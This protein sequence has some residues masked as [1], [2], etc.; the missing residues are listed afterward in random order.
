MN[1]DDAKSRIQKYL[2]SDKSWPLI[3][4]VQTKKNLAEIKEFFRV[5]DNK[6]PDIENFCNADGMLK[7]DELYSAIRN[8]SNNLFITCLTGFL[9]LMGESKIKSTLK[10][11]IS[12][13][14]NSRVVI[15][16]YQ[17]KNYLKFS[18]ER[19][20]ESGRFIIVDDIPDE[21]AEIVLVNPSLYESLP[22]AYL[23]IQKVGY[24]IENSYQKRIYVATDVKKES[25]IESVFHISQMTSGYNLL[26]DRDSR[27]S[28]VPE[29]FGEDSQWNY[30]L[31]EMGNKGDWKYVIEK[32]FGSEDNLSQVITTYAHLNKKHLWLYY[33][34]LSICGVKNNAYL[35]MSVDCSSGPA[36]FIKSIYRTILTIDKDNK[37]FASLYE[38]RKII[39]SYLT[40]TLGEMA[41]YCKVISVKG[42]DAIYYLTDLTQLEKER[43]VEWLNIY[44]L[45]YK[46]NELVRILKRVYP[47]LSDYLSDFRFKNELLDDYFEQ[48]KYQ[49]VV[50]HILPSF[51]TLV[52]EQSIKMDFVSALKPRSSI[53]DKVSVDNTQ[54]YFF[55]ALG[56]EYLGFIQA[57]C[58]EYGLSANIKC[59]R[60]EL[61]SLTSFNKEFVDVLKSKG[62]SVT[63]IKE[64]DEIKH[65][66]ENNFDYEKEKN[67]IYLIRELEI[68]NELIDKIKIGIYGGQYKKALI[69]SDHGASRLAVLHETENI[70][71]MESKGEHSGRCCRT[72]EI[73]TKPDF[74]IEQSGFWVLANY[75]R[76]KGGRK[77]N[78]EVHGG[79]TIEEVTIPIIEITQKH[80]DIEAFIIEEY[81]VVSLGAL[82]HAI[83]K[84]YV[85]TKSDNI[86]I[87]IDNKYYDANPTSDIYVYEIEL[88]DYTK[89]GNYK[90]DILNGGEILATDVQFEIKKKG[91]SEV[92]LFD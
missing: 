57:K 35:Q 9:K 43:I 91:M 32:H 48:Y 68:I 60:C 6:F 23:G 17:C 83:I 8:G 88:Q 39:L 44:G 59:A 45:N 36:E 80:Y 87:R 7:L 55:D 61:P 22:G 25:F 4:D 86:S 28:I 53:I 19:I 21:I 27:T 49:K 89:K 18:D 13:D 54:A 71:S 76:F 77:A 3:V 15:I 73:N 1:L 79:A 11:L 56:V 5:G 29:S 72:S 84:I 63:D 66:G 47:D 14:V 78:V 37:D 50:N 10:T 65:H 31:Q 16:T 33:I 26:C 90:F 46:K 75:D 69:V 92:N 52:E 42:E 58:N 38:Q 40:N 70:W 74:A 41:E 24:A 67:P 85:G 20:A 12:T 64:L 62:C 34:A 81:K 30:A 82:E 51:E 2:K